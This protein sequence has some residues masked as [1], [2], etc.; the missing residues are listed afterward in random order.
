MPAYTSPLVLCRYQQCCLETC[1][2]LIHGS[3]YCGDFKLFNLLC[4]FQ[5]PLPTRPHWYLLFGASEEEIKEICIT[6]LKLY[7]RKKVKHLQSAIV[8]HA[9]FLHQNSL[10]P[11]HSGLFPGLSMT[12]MVCVLQ[13]LI[14]FLCVC[15]NICSLRSC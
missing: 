12:C 8:I 11:F 3:C 1:S 6:T 7:T 2:S 9:A 4:F 14:L 5:L 10:V 15:R 13:P